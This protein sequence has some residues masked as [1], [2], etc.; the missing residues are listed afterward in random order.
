MSAK[1]LL[2]TIGS[3][4]KSVF[5]WFLSAQGQKVIQTGEAIAE[6]IDPGLTGVINIAN[7]WMAEII[8]TQA[9]ATAA[10]MQS[11]SDKEK[12]AM[13]INA[14]TPEILAFAKQ[15]GLPIPTADKIQKAND[16]LVLFLNAL[17]GKS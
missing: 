5:K 7:S 9:L 16:A 4:A 1:S 13:T 17:D 10:G 11:G 3:D 8:R 14:V 6:A 15:N 12:A 2:D